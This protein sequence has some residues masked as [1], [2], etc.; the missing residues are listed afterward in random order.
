M[1]LYHGGCNLFTETALPEIVEKDCQARKLNRDAADRVCY[2][3]MI[4]YCTSPNISAVRGKCWNAKIGSFL[5][6]AVLV[7]CQT[8]TIAG[9]IYSV[10]LF[11]TH[12]VAAV[13]LPKFCRHWYYALGRLGA[14]AQKERKIG[15]LH[16]SKWTMFNAISISTPCCWTIK[17]PSVTRFIAFNICWDSMIFQQYCLLVFTPGLVKNNEWCKNSCKN[18]LW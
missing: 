3:K 1:P 11:T 16:H 12:A 4:C 5:S 6:H 7:H 2:R 13:W 8:L 17:L 14:I 10:L 15:V 9:L 18:S